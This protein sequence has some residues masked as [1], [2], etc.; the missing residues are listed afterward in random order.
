MILAVFLALALL[1]LAPLAWVLYRVGGTRGTRDPALLL[2]RTQLGELDRDLAEGRIL[3]AEHA[4]AL[5]EV[6]RRLLAVADDRPV[7]TGSSTPVL[8]TLL[9]VP[10]LA[11]G[12]YLVGGQPGMPTLSADSPEMALIKRRAAD[13]A[14]VDTLRQRV[15]AQDARTPQAREG[16]VLLGTVEEARGNDAAAAEAWVQALQSRFDPALA[17]R[18]AEALTRAEGHVTEASAALFR[19][20]LQGAAPDAPWRA[21]AEARLGPT[22]FGPRR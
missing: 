20:A 14:L 4:T 18:A 1:A 19:R 6:Q 7:R 11:M 9:L 16:Y 12:L 15:Q 8:V 10:V 3:P 2:H 5:L 21:V 13:D 17:V 22:A